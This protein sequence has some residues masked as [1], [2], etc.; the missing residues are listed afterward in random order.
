MHLQ[1]HTILGLIIAS[2]FV[3]CGHTPAAKTDSEELILSNQDDNSNHLDDTNYN[4]KSS[5]KHPKQRDA[6]STFVLISAQ[7][8]ELLK[9]QACKQKLKELVPKPVAFK[10]LVGMSAKMQWDVKLNLKNFHWCFY[11]MMV[12]MDQELAQSNRSF[13]EQGD[14]FILAM[15]RMYVTAHALGNILGVNTYMDYLRVRYVQ[16]S[17]QKFG[18]SLTSD[19]GQIFPK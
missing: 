3:A 9:V 18:R 16:I 7:K 15:Q 10:E 5:L 13:S 4:P 17:Q 12:D 19:K 6:A 14:L 11:Q 8:P 2:S 1:W